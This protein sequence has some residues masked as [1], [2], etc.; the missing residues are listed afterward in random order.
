MINKID[1]VN[2]DETN[3]LYSALMML[4]EIQH[5]V[6]SMVPGAITDAPPSPDQIRTYFL[7]MAVEIYELMSE[8][9]GWKPWKEPKAVNRERVVDEF[10]DILAF[11][12]VILN[13]IDQLGISMVDLARGYAHKTNVNISRFNGEVDGYRIERDDE[14]SPIRRQGGVE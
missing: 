10:A 13:Y 14:A 5:D 1:R 12:G 9:P 8:F 11:T 4:K 6:S 3:S 2:Q 7:A